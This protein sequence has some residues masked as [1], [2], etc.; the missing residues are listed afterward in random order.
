MVK[1]DISEMGNN[2]IRFGLFNE[3]NQ[4][5]DHY[6]VKREMKDRALERARKTYMK[7][8]RSVCVNDMTVS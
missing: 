3:A 4:V 5:I 6:L 8:G 1:I 2:Q 7:Q